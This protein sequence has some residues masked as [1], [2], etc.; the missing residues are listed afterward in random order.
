MRGLV[1]RW[2]VNAA[3]LYVTAEVIEGVEAVGAEAILVAAALLGIVNA[4]V[5]PIL[6]LLTLPLN[7]LTLGL[8]TF[9]INGLLLWLVSQAVAGFTVIGFLPAFMG[10][11]VLSVVS[12]LINWL[13]RDR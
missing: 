7:I 1:I 2:V 12:A 8:F 5:R 11:L 9:V 6:I 13:V 10:A 4:F 3:A